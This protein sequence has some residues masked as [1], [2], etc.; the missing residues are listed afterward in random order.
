MNAFDIVTNVKIVSTRLQ[1]PLENIVV[2]DEAADVLYN[3]NTECENISAFV[4]QEIW[5]KLL[6]KR[7]VV[8]TSFR[9]GFKTQS[10]KDKELK[11]WIYLDDSGLGFDKGT[12][13]RG[14]VHCLSLD[15]LLRHKQWRNAIGDKE[16]MDSLSE[17]MK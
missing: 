16:W 17:A 1:L 11:V 4:S 7:G 2:F 10:F 3:F 6:N 13:V 14:G 15:D 12:E 5:D 8:R 9:R